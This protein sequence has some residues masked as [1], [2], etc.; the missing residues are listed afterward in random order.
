[1]AQNGEKTDFFVQAFLGVIAML[2]LFVV[3]LWFAKRVV[4]LDPAFAVGWVDYQLL[5]GVDSITRH[6][7]FAFLKPNYEQCLHFITMVLNGS[8]PARLVT[9]KQ[10]GYI[11]NN[12]SL[13]MALPAAFIIAVIGVTCLCIKRPVSMKR[14]F[15]MRGFTYTKMTR[16]NGNLL[17]KNKLLS[18]IMK[19][20]YEKI[21]H[22]KPASAFERHKDANDFVAFQAKQWRHVTTSAHFN[23]DLN[24]KQWAIAKNPIPWCMERKIFNINQENFDDIATKNFIKQLGKNLN[25]VDKAP[26]HVKALMALFWLNRTAGQ[27]KTYEFAGQLAELILPHK[28]IPAPKVIA[29]ADAILN[30]PKKSNL[31]DNQNAKEYMTKVIKQYTGTNTIM[32]ALYYLCGPFS[33]YDGG[34]TGVLAPNA[35]MW[36]K[37]VDRPLWYTLNNVG[38]GNNRLEGIAPHAQLARE[39]KAG[40]RCTI[41]VSSA[42]RGL[43]LYLQRRHIESITGEIEAMRRAQS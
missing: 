35:F 32:A 42:V 19:L 20:V 15:S 11:S 43:R 3:I 28:P 36:L 18:F 8:Y 21:L 24:D 27:K 17:P 38:P 22:V 5:I 10:V 33:M 39:Y 16:Y 9:L 37:G 26:A 6:M 41:D 40:E 29:L 7:H 2:V 4:L 1:M 14:K 31:V 25:D 13:A 12:L 34:N 30:N 23:V